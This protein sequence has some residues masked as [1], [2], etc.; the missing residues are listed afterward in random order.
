MQEI[1]TNFAQGNWGNIKLQSY[2]YDENNR[3]IQETITYEVWPDTNWFSSGKNIFQ[4]DDVGNLLTNRYY[5]WLAKTN[6]YNGPDSSIVSFAYTNNRPDSFVLSSVYPPNRIIGRYSFSTDNDT[7]V[8]HHEYITTTNVYDGQHNKTSLT[9]F[10]SD[11]DAFYSAPYRYE[12]SYNA[13]NQVTCQRGYYLDTASNAWVFSNLI[14]YYYENY[15]PE[16]TFNINTISIFPSPARGS[17]TVKLEWPKAAA[18]NCAIFDAAGHR[19]MQWSVP[20]TQKYEQ[21]VSLPFLASG[22]YL[23]RAATSGQKM[24]KQFVLIN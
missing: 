13:Y 11:S 1:D 2:T 16:V 9:Q 5:E 21:T 3:I 20:A 8:V 4:Y 14:K 6:L 23:L 12:Y 7:M 24:V 10:I 15:T 22:N 19:V 17:I 18:F